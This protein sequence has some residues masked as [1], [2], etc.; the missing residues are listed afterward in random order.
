MLLPFWA[1]WLKL[2]CLDQNCG[3]RFRLVAT[4]PLEAVKPSVSVLALLV[5][6]FGGDEILKWFM[7]PVE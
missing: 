6:I 5:R 4:Y 2:G 7:F 1:F 3:W